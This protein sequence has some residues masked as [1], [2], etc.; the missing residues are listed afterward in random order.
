MQL[1]LF[2]VV[3]FFVYLAPILWVELVACSNISCEELHFIL[4]CIH[5]LVSAVKNLIWV[6]DRSLTFMDCIFVKKFYLNTYWV[7]DSKII[8]VSVDQIVPSHKSTWER[9][10]KKWSDCLQRHAFFQL[11]F[12][13]CSLTHRVIWIPGCLGRPWHSPQPHWSLATWHHPPTHFFLLFS[14]VKG[15]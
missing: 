10:K 15:T 3:C 14:T 4:D 5:S 2:Q 1:P 6:S 8:F 13:G 12:W 9:E 7:D 11:F